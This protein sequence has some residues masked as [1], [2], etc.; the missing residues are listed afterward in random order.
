MSPNAVLNGLLAT[1]GWSR[2]HTADLINER[3]HEGGHRQVAVSKGRVATWINRDQTPAPP[4]PGILADLLSQRLGRWL[5]PAELGFTGSCADAAFE[6]NPWHGDP[7]GHLI[8]QGTADMTLH[9]RDVVR[10]GMFS[11]AACAVPSTQ[12]KGAD[13]PAVGAQRRAGSADVARIQEV[14]RQFTTL[15]HAYGGGHARRALATYLVYEVAPLLRGAR[16]P[17]RSE[18][19]RAAA[20][21]AYRAGWMALDDD[22]HGLAQRY[23]IATVR[24][25]SEAGDMAL[26][27]SALRAMARQAV[28]LGHAA[29]AV[30]LAEVAMSTAGTHAPSYSMASYAGTLADAQAATGDRHAALKT[31]SRAERLVDQTESPAHLWT[32]T[33]RRHSL[34]WDTGKVLSHLHDHAGAAA[35]LAASLSVLPAQQRRNRTLFHARLARN[36]VATRMPA[37]AAAT[38][39]AIEADLSL[40]PSAR[41]TAELR[42]LRREWRPYRADSEVA[43]A[44]LM[45]STFT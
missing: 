21:L 18:L 26:R 31:L 22:A 29:E 10:V 8:S 20:S 3:A 7:V 23:Y 41:V 40:A 38:V 28:D 14:G 45:L 32:G 35:H 13:L 1:A 24:L 27:S 37:A 30:N 6:A 16:G 34:E 4:V 42:A 2:Q 9:R 33:Y 44:D 19:F 12:A 17:A 43:T 5:T 36:Q 15:E 39:Q 11:V 25:A